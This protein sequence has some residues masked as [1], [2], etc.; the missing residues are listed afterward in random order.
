MQKQNQGNF[1][2]NDFVKMGER[3]S[4]EQVEEG[5]VSVKRKQHRNLQEESR[6]NWI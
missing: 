6:E 4:M 3:Y 1:K 5:A 2:K